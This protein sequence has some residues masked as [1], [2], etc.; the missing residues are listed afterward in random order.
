M[1]RKLVVLTYD[2][3]PDRDPDEYEAYVRREDYPTFRER[4]SVLEYSGFRITKNHVGQQSFSM[5]D[6]MFVD[7]FESFDRDVLGDPKVARHADGW[8]DQW[9]PYG[10]QEPHQSGRN[11]QVFFAEE[12]WG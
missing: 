4:P 5:F 8:I 3:H 10:G 9:A 11:Y 7:D 1:S 2:L 6:L 12:L